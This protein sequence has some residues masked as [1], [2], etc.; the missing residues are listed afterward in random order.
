[1]RALASPRELGLVGFIAI[2]FILFHFDFSGLRQPALGG[3]I[4]RPGELVVKPDN[5][6]TTSEP[7][8][9]VLQTKIVHHVPGES[10]RTR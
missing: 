3:G 9:G 1:M 4:Q 2:C 10:A 6:T 5:E 7:Q 8:D